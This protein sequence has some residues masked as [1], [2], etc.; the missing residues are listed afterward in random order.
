MDKT[1]GYFRDKCPEMHSRLVLLN[2]LNCEVD[3]AAK[4][5]CPLC[6]K[7]CGPDLWGRSGKIVDELALLHINATGFG[8][9]AQKLRTCKFSPPVVLRQNIIVQHCYAKSFSNTKT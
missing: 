3:F 9:F 5:L 6:R 8:K 7:E 2:T 1:A 4:E